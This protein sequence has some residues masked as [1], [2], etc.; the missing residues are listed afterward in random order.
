[1][2]RKHGVI[3]VNLS[4]IKIGIEGEEF[5]NSEASHTSKTELPIIAR[6]RRVA[7]FEK[8]HV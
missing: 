4:H 3:S 1:M 6:S 7:F 5:R 8:Q 2:L